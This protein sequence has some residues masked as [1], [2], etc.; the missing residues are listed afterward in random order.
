MATIRTFC[1][2][3]QPEHLTVLDEV[4]RAFLT[5][6]DYLREAEALA[7][8]AANVAASPFRHRISVPRPVKELC[9]KHVLVMEYL[10]GAR[11]HLPA[12]LPAAPASRSHR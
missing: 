12:A 4:E 7:E 10:P 6:F 2:I 5:E 3:A 9:R 11:P 8:V 1:T